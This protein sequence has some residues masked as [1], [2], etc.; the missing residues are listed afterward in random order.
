[1][2]KRKTVNEK[3]DF[4]KEF[5]DVIRK[6]AYTRS[7]W[8]VWGDFLYV[9]AVS[10]ANIF[11]TAEREE[12]EKE[13]LSIVNCYSK[14]EQE[15]LLQLS[16]LVVLA[17]EDNPEQDFLGSMYHRLNL[18]QEQKGQFF[19]PYHIS[20]FMAMIQFEKESL[21]E[22]LKEK[23]YISVSDPACGAGVMLIAFANVA[24][25]HGINYQ[26]NILFEAQDVDPTAALMCYIQLSLLGCPAVVIIG[27]SLL[28]PGIQDSND[29]WYTPF[30]YMNYWRFK[31]KRKSE[32]E[33]SVVE[34][35]DGQKKP[36]LNETA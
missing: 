24:R 22:E 1:M 7:L 20:H 33:V 26:Q 21:E 5:E 9:S 16:V 3:R 28:N 8:K 31:R 34:N 4:A 27:D 35:Q 15:L 10:M 11:P 18:H 19:T 14:K 17:L 36:D 2:N 29:V 13:Y 32:T 23:G 12:R 6:L 30:Y 25:T